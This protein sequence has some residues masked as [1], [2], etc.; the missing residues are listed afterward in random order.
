MNP[1]NI[2]HAVY[3]GGG[4]VAEILLHV[5]QYVGQTLQAHQEIRQ[6]SPLELIMQMNRVPLDLTNNFNY[7][8]NYNK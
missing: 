3:I 1:E 5:A 6:T 2:Q 4:I 7:P 8:S